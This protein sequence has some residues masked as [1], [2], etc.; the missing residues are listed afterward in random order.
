MARQYQ[1]TQRIRLE[2]GFTSALIRL[3]IAPGRWY[4]LAVKG[5]VSGELRE[6]PIEPIEMEGRRF[7][8]APF[9]VVN[10][11]KNARK[12]GRVRLSRGAR[13][14]FLEVK[15]MTPSE[16]AP[17][18]RAYLRRGYT[19]DY[20]NAGPDSPLTEFENE[21]S[22]HPVFLDAGPASPFD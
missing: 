1:V 3:G 11:V 16:S 18:L 5:R 22:H 20:F 9:G 8:V 21:A 7:F 4:L 13:V 10:W 17:V 2:N 19:G 12:A 14:E 15:E 6:T